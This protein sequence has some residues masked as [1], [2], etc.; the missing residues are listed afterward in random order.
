MHTAAA[1]VNTVL[2]GKSLTG[3]LRAA[4]DYV[5]QFR[6]Q[7]YVCVLETILL[8]WKFGVSEGAT[9]CKTRRTVSTNFEVDKWREGRK[10]THLGERKK[11]WKTRRESR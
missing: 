6:V 7:A 1:H 11:L 5:Q 8:L 2:R 3:K 4:T 10:Y 9:K